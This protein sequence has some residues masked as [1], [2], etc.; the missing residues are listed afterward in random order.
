MTVRKLTDNTSVNVYNNTTY[1]IGY[2]VEGIKRREWTY[3]ANPIIK[4]PLGEIENALGDVGCYNMYTR[5]KLLIKDTDVREHL[6]LPP[7]DD[8]INYDDVKE[9]LSGKNVS[10]IEE[11]LK[12]AKE[13]HDMRVL[14][15]VA[16]LAIELR[17]G[18]LTILSMIKEYAG[19]DVEEAI[20][21]AIEEDDKK[22]AK[23]KATS[24]K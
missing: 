16:D 15:M 20:K 4:I 2:Y 17:V 22:K 19:K 23:G 13:I 5:N 21:D 10:A 14:E 3:G 9:M 6:G 24:K 12:N 1:D 18:D 7:L 8:V 11:T